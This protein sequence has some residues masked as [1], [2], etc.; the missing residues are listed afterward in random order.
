MNLSL[1]YT[2]LF[3]ICLVGSCQVETVNH[4]QVQ[5]FDLNDFIQEE[6]KRIANVEKIKKTVSV[7]GKTEEKILEV[8]DLKKDLEIFT[9]SNI[10]K[11]AL[12]DKY[13][14]DS[15]FENNVLTKIQ[16]TANDE[17][18]KTREIIVNY[19]NKSV[20]SVSIRN[21]SSNAVT[22]SEQELLFQTNKGYSIKSKQ[23][24]SLS[25]EQIRSVEV[26][27]LLDK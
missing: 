26:E 21:A 27:F 25:K 8:F 18:V 10:N 16:Y 23:K 12:L 22:I 17:K 13:D 6:S 20:Q 19:K 14:V 24:V 1:K 5:F 15:I 3:F 7:N 9:N 11:I 4:I 2:L